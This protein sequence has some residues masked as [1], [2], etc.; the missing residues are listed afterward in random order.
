M[1][2][3]AIN[4]Y[5]QEGVIPLLREGP[6]YLAEQLLH[7]ITI[8][9]VMQTSVTNDE[10]ADRS[11]DQGSEA[12]QKWFYGSETSLEISPPYTGR[13]P[14]TFEHLTGVHRS[15]RPFVQ[16]LSDARLVGPYAISQTSGGETLFDELGTKNT[17]YERTRDTWKTLGTAKTVQELL[18]G[19]DRPSEPPEYGTIINM[20]PRHGQS[21]EHV[22]YGAWFLEDLPRLRALEQETAPDAKLLIRPDL[23]EWA[24][25][26]L[27]IMGFS[28]EDWVYWNGGVSRAERLVLPRLY[29]IHSFGSDFNPS[30]RQWVR[31]RLKAG[32][33]I[34]GTPD[35]G[36]R[37]FLSRQGQKRRKIVNFDELQDTLRPFEFET[38][39]PEE[40]SMRELINIYDSAEFILGPHGSGMADMIY[41]SDATVVEIFPKNEVR[42]VFY[43]TANE[44]GHEY[45]FIEGENPPGVSYRPTRN[46]NIL[47]DTDEVRD[48]VQQSIRDTDT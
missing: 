40:Y 42:P 20:V 29:L 27:Q 12:Y 4:K 17:A 2:N 7:E 14:E 10:L 1:I 11:T 33:K 18:L 25:E 28:E 21:D 47:V 3:K 15:P 19:G 32:V 30:G 38:I 24:K 48:V 26:A 41:A 34:D 39:R 35:V 37:L 22:N 5:R 46:K 8:A 16:E 45:D 43:I 9:V 13:I 23:P 36:P 6:Q 31:D 44:F